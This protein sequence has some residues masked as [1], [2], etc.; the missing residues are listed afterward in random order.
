MKRKLIETRQQ[1]LVKCDNVSCD[2]VVD[3]KT[4]DINEDSIEYINKP[5]P[6]CRENLLTE[7]DYL[8]H[9]KVV[10]MINFI[11]KWFSWLTIFLRENDKEKEYVVNTHRKIQITEKE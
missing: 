5:C 1:H 2:F 8:N 9:Q 11:N 3:S 7:T 6:K 4:G 10:K